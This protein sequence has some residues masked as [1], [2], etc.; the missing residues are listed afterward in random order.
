MDDKGKVIVLSTLGVEGE[1]WDFLHNIKN[2][3]ILSYESLKYKFIHNYMGRNTE[4]LY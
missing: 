2:L 1:A 3:D 4:H